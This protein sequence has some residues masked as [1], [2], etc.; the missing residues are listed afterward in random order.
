VA[1]ALVFSRWAV[2]ARSHVL[3][4]RQATEEE[5]QGTGVPSPPYG[6]PKGYHMGPGAAGFAFGA[7]FRFCGPWTHV[8]RLRP[9]HTE[10]RTHQAPFYCANAP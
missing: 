6:L 7:C 2:A 1:L 9:G 5:D 10:M 3:A 4:G 8:M